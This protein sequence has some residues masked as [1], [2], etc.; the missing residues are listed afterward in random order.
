[1]ALGA[2]SGACLPGG[3]SLQ[4]PVDL[5]PQFYPPQVREEPLLLVPAKKRTHSKHYMPRVTDLRFSR[6]RFSFVREWCQ[7]YSWLRAGGGG[8]GSLPSP[9]FSFI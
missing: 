1:M 7:Y 6:L 8:G 2:V 9:A 5:Y 3:L 4:G